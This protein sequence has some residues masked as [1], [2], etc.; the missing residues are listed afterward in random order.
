MSVYKKTAKGLI[1]VVQPSRPIASKPNP[2]AGGIF[3][4]PP[5]PAKRSGI[6]ISRWPLGPRDRNED[7]GIFTSQGNL[8]RGS[9]NYPSDAPV[10]GAPENEG[11]TNEEALLELKKKFGFPPLYAETRTIP[12]QINDSERNS[13]LRFAL[14]AFLLYWW[15]G[16]KK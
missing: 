12:E 13:W 6:F 9:A 4:Q 2:W 5:S 16:R 1:E 15:V 8:I 14:L 7:E 3:G 11:T 10:L